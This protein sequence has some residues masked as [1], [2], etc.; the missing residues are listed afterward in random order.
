[1]PSIVFRPMDESDLGLLVGWRHEP[2][3]LAWFRDPPADVPDAR[4]WYG[5]RLSGDDPTRMWVV[6]V[7]GAPV[8]SLQDYPVAADDDLAVRVQLPGSVGFDYLIGDPREVGRGLGTQVLAAYL[9]D[10]VLPGH[11]DA[12]WFVACPDARN[13][14]SLRVLDKLGFAQRQWIQMPGEEYAQIVC[15]ASRDHVAGPVTDE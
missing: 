12:R 15:R 1:M 9:R 6:E 13:A 5:A 10:V 8:G 14:A 3:V 4:K 7:D 2:H 11:R